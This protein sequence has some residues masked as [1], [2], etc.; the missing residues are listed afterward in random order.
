M[1]KLIRALQRAYLTFVK[2]LHTIVVNLL[3]II[4]LVLIPILIIAFCVL[5]AAEEVEY[6]LPIAVMLIALCFI[7]NS[8]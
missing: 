6:L 8:L 4:T 1:R 2:A 7:S 5:L 3:S